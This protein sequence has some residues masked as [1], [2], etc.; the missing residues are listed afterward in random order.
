MDRRKFIRNTGSS[1]AA[2]SLL[3]LPASFKLKGMPHRVLG[4]TG[5][6]VSILGVGGH[7]IGNRRITDETS[8]AVIRGAIDMGVNFFDN[9]WD[10]NNGRSEE[11]MGKALQDGYREKVYLMTKHH[12]R[13]PKTAQLHLEESLKRLKTDYL[14]VW[15]FHEIM[16]LEDVEKIHTSGVL[17]FALK[18]KEQGKVKHIGFT[19]HANPAV[20]KAMLERGFEWETVQ[21]PVNVLDHHYL[22]FS[23]EI[24]PLLVERNIGIIGMKSASSGN[25]IKNNIATAEE[26]LTFAMSLP[27]STLIS[28]MEKLEYLHE[29]VRIAKNFSPMQEEKMI[30]LL[31]KTYDHA[32]GGTHE[33]YKKTTY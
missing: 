24:I 31:E 7:H 25:I 2:L 30:A 27:I 11:L 5:L 14:D 1:M 4:K 6:K 26:C 10:Y 12:G 15:Q 9:A 16:T 17:D 3:G 32:K 23:Q 29:N 8:L 19:G 13:E 18:M 20:H 22:S 21:M 28:G 33:W